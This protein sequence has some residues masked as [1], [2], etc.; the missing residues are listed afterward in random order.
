[1]IVVENQEFLVSVKSII[2]FSGNKYESVR[3]LITRNK[4]KFIQPR[5]TILLDEKN[6]ENDS[7]YKVA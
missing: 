3:D 4:S 5:P 6:L 2:D 7:V 1:M